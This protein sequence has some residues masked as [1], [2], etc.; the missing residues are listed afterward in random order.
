MAWPDEEA[1][2]L[3]EIADQLKHED[4]TLAEALCRFEACR[5][6]VPLRHTILRL[7][8]VVA[9]LLLVALLLLIATGLVLTMALLG[10][11]SL[12]CWA[13]VRRTQEAAGRRLNTRT[14]R[15]LDSD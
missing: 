15:Q 1:I 4:P 12:A 3:R 8:G 11:I 14:R 10:G 7:A 6:P 5:R 13:Y 9:G 2:V